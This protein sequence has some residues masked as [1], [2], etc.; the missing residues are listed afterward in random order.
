MT[1]D[2]A[3]HVVVKVSDVAGTIQGTVFPMRP[4]AYAAIGDIMEE[5]KKR[6]HLSIL[7]KDGLVAINIDHI[8]L[9]NEK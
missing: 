2:I 5:A 4:E 3:I 1:K 6:G 8:I 7:T 9:I